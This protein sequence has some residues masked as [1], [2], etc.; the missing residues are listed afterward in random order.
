VGN[1][2]APGAPAQA[3][4]PSTVV[5]AIGRHRR[6][7]LLCAVALAV[8]GVAA[9]ATRKPVYT[10]A[11]TL[12]VGKVNPNS[13]GFYGFV[14]SATDLAAVFSRA[15]TA[16]P[17]LDAVH[18]KLGLSPIEAAERLAAEPIPSSPAFRVIATGPSQPAAVALANVTSAALI[19]YEADANTYSPESQRLLDE[20]RGASMNLSN[21][22]AAVNVAA[23]AYALHPDPP[24]HA[25]LVQTQAARAAASLQTQ[26]LASGYELSA[27]SAT[28]RDLISP[29]AD[30]VSA[31]SD[32]SSKIQLDGFLGLL[33]GLVIGCAI[34]VLYEQRRAHA[35]SL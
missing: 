24:A 17:V 6:L 21:S 1:S 27:E 5:T 29:L 25:K 15:I 34:A 30:A 26:A 10:A 22:V 12:Q 2:H 11:S 32:R 7:V 19:A 13:P 28:T 20:Y 9:G 23:S 8:L 18:N 35:R 33:G 31:S 16:S 3:P 4:L 14:Q